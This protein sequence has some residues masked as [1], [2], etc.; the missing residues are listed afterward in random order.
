MTKTHFKTLAPLL[1]VAATLSFF[2]CGGG[3]GGG[4]G[5]SA[6]VTGVVSQQVAMVDAPDCYVMVAGQTMDAGTICVDMMDD[7]LEVTDHAT[8]DWK[9]YEAQVWI[10]DGLDEMPQTPTG[11]PKIGNFPYKAEDLGGVSAYTF[12]IPLS[13]LGPEEEL[14]D[15]EFYLAAHATLGR[16][17]E[18]EEEMQF[19]TAWSDGMGFNVRGSWAMVSTFVFTCDQEPEPP[20]AGFECETAF[21][22]GDTTFIELGLTNGRWGWMVTIEEF[23]VYSTPIYADAG[24]NDISKGVHVGDLNYEYDGAQLFVS[25]DM[26]EPFV[27]EKTHLY[28][29][30][31]PVGTTAPGRFGNQHDLDLSES[32]S[33]VVDI[34]ADTVYRVAHAVVCAP[35]EEEPAL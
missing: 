13:D 21:A 6:Q 18:G 28:V 30:D 1:L 33:Y 23:G 4:G 17:V 19:E 10:G 15:V 24:G 32:D 26:F 31:V 8:G 35:E 27:L 22:Y 14:C 5:P 29:G 3:G 20:V 12:S 7:T 9:I 16:M 2:S 11:N 25:Y 34:V